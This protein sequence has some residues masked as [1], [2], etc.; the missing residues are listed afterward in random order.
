MPATTTLSSEFI[1]NGFRRSGLTEAS[2]SAR[3][4]GIGSQN[5][6]VCLD[7]GLEVVGLCEFSHWVCCVSVALSAKILL[8]ETNDG[9][10]R[11]A[12]D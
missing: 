2:Q 3:P 4:T 5:V 6:V 7:D 8:V 1:L 10:G 9:L 11:K 12:P